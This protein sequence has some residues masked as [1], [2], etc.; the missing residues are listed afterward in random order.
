ME[1]GVTHLIQLA[2]QPLSCGLVA[3]KDQEAWRT[4]CEFK[5]IDEWEKNVGRELPAWTGLRRPSANNYIILVDQ[6]VPIFVHERNH[7]A[8]ELDQLRYLYGNDRIDIHYL[9]R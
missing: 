7:Q 1:V 5:S 2:D 8:I 6:L 9:R 4:Q 3:M